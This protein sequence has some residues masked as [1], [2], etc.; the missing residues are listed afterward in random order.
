MGATFP[1]VVT[2]ENIEFL[3]KLVRNGRDKYPG[4]N[5]V[6][7]SVNLISGQKIRQIDLRYSKEKVELRYGDIVERHLMN[8][9]IVLL[10]RQ[11]TLHKQSMM[12][13]R[14]RVIDNP[15]YSTFR[16]SLAVCK[17]Y[18]A[19]F[20]GDEMN[21]FIP[22]SIQTKMELEEIADVKYQI[23]SPTHSKTIIGINQDCLIGAYN[24]TSPTMKI[25]WRNA[26]NILSYTS[27]EDF[28]KIKKDDINGKDMA[29]LI[30][31]SKTN[32]N[33]GG[34]KVEKGKIIEG[35]LA[36]SSLGE[37]SDLAIHK[38][39]WDEYGADETI[40]FLDNSHRLF[41]NFNLYYG[42]TVGIK[43]IEYNKK[44]GE[45]YNKIFETKKNKTNYY[46]TELENYPNLAKDDIGERVLLADYNV[47]RDEITKII[48]NNIRKDNNFVIM[49]SS[50]SK[51]NDDNICQ[52]FGAIGLQV[53]EGKMVPKRIN[54][55]TLPYFFQNDDRGESRGLIK[56]SFFKGI[57]YMEYFYALMSARSGVIDGAVKTASSGY[58]QRK[59]VKTLE[60]IMIKYD[61]TVRGA[62]N[63]IL[64]FV[65]GDSGADTTKQNS[66]DL[67][68]MKM[69]NKEIRDKI[70]FTESE[71]K[72]YSFSESKNEEI[73]NE[74]IKI[75]D[76]FRENK[77]KSYMNYV[78]LNSNFMI[79]V[80]MNRIINNTK[81]DVELNKLTD[82]LNADY[83]YENINKLISNDETM[84]MC[85]KKTSKDSIK[86]KDSKLHKL[87]LKV[88]LFE[89]LSPALCIKEHNLNKGQFDEILKQVKNSFNK[90]MV[91][92][93]EMVGVIAAQSLGEP[94]TQ[95]TLKSF[96][97]AGISN[98]GDLTQGVPRVNELLSLSNKIKTPQMI[99]YLNDDLKNNKEMSEK[100]ASHLE[101]ITLR[102]IRKKINVYYDNDPYS[103]D[104]FMEQDN[105]KKVFYNQ[106]SNSKYSC[107]E[108]FNGLPWLLR[109][110]LD[111]EKMLSKNITLLD[112]KSSFCNSWEKRY[113]DIKNIKKDEKT[114]LDKILNC[115]IGSNTDNDQNAILHIRF[116]M[117][118]YDIQ[119]INDFIDIIID[120]HKLNGIPNID[121]A[122]VSEDRI[123]SFNKFGDVVT[124]NNWVIYTAGV[125]LIDIRYING[126]NINNVICNDIVAVYNTFGIEAA[127]T[128]LIREIYLAYERAGPRVNFQHICLLSDLMTMNGYL[129]SIDRHGSKKSDIDPLSRASFEQ[130]I[131]QLI[132]SAVFNEIDHMNGVSSR[133]MAG[134]VIKGGTGYCDII[135]DTDMI[136][137]SEFTE[138]IGQKY[139]KTF[140]PVSQ[141][142]MLNYLLNENDNYE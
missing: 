17:P 6:F 5:F 82:K 42:F 118:N 130:P 83:V 101:L 100:I 102:D 24:L 131:E 65:Y 7:P 32:I 67:K 27:L 8:D 71:L 62:N 93:G 138:D 106:R 44:L 114:I 73:Y 53:I 117:I 25:D 85:V 31:P 81:N 13:H 20:D 15:E 10:N 142:S 18:N 92:P 30:I 133:V 127:R 9:D 134:L 41:N 1:E 51:G 55:R 129:V 39:T 116:E 135:L 26:M 97:T 75:R 60:D 4:A 98:I 121:N 49:K 40:K 36:K 119:I 72:K 54:K 128:T 3:K 59:L 124:N 14:I 21:I 50:G 122:N 37:G 120:K 90:N 56:N 35:R 48:N 46:I 57:N 23:I 140:V 136:Q 99:I 123:V 43:D 78:T 70:V 61:C 52:I 88:V 89:N 68:I 45:E 86:E 95:M 12:G 110:E 96:H 47:V 84:M 115:A 141:D 11:P 28:R 132:N 2:P 103:K 19:D 108:S 107:N 94:T 105:I 66:Y 79:P 137:N 74:L 76:L 126:I 38:Y 58:I 69:N 64:Q 22:Q 63:A 104:G 34:F 109:I 87:L 16:L 112:I 80:N 77:L 33:G 113:S 29:S 125:N 91:E 139:Q 111:R